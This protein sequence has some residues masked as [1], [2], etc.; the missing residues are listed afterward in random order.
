MPLPRLI[1]PLELATLAWPKSIRPD[2]LGP[3][4]TSLITRT[5]AGPGKIQVAGVAFDTHL[6][7]IEIVT[8]GE[9]GV[10]TWR[11]RTDGV[12]WG[13]TQL[14]STV[15]QAVLHTAVDELTGG[16]DIG[17]RVSFVAGSPAPSFVAGDRIDLTT[18]P[19]QAI[20]AQLL[21]VSEDLLELLGARYQALATATFTN[22]GLKRHIAVLARL[23]LAESR[24][25]DP[26]SA[27][28]KLY[29]DS[30]AR[31]RAHL[32]EIA[33]KLTHPTGLAEGPVYSPDV[34]EGGDRYGIARAH[35][36]RGD[37]R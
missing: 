4:Q 11:A 3:G 9:P 26:S 6:V 28:G 24:G 18:K 23:N 32:V 13:D 36:A 30:A 19:V 37:A 27:D 14:T 22:P 20:V 5:A 31:S 34:Y 15:E 2:E 35:R 12:T 7:R 10:A 25:L 8:G 21:A 29:I 33:E 16:A 1:A 17:L